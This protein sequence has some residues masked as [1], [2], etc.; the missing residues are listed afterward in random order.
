ML[1]SGN[2]RVSPLCQ[3]AFFLIL[4]VTFASLAAAQEE[5]KA[6][7]A[8]SGPA[9]VGPEAC[10]TCHEDIYKG[11]EA[12][13]HWKTT[14]DK[15]GGAAKQGCESCHG[16]AGD[17]IDDPGDSSKIFSFKNASAQKINERCLECHS[18]GKDHANFSRS[19][20]S[21]NNLSCLS[22][23]SPH[24]AK[25]N[26][27]LLVKAQ[28]Q[29]CFTCHLNVK[30]QFSMP[31][32]HRVN[33]GLVQCSDC[34]NPHGGFLSKQLRS[35]AA[36]DA[37]CFTC[38]VDKQGPFVFEHQPV[39]IEGCVSCHVPHGSPNPHMMKQSNLN[40]LCLQCH[41]AS[42]F[43]AAPGTPQFHSQAAQFQ[44]C[45][46]CHTAI[47]GSNFDRHFMK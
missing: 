6:L 2:A 30:P 33:E 10:K 9:Y 12:S 21:E 36:Q 19:A 44:A 24:H 37:V 26:Q 27:F 13:P 17:H 28:P 41:T 16:P 32:H 29:L 39:K 8:Q 1:E 7:P 38:H 11:F 45:I 4:S 46:I 15:R 31:F 14:L 34:H 35:A 5:K 3:L 22:C 47:H 42:S 18:S 20:H 25:T 40:L 23:H 43:S